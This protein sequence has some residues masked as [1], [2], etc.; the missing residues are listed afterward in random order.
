[1]KCEYLGGAGRESNPEPADQ[2]SAFYYYARY[3]AIPEAIR[4]CRFVHVTAI[5]D[6]GWCRTLTAST[7]ADEQTPSKHVGHD[8]GLA[9]RETRQFSGT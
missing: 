4:R 6:A 7:G 8:F 9:H 2:E 3:Q 1:M 5:C